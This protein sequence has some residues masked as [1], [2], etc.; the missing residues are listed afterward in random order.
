MQTLFNIWAIGFLFMM[1]FIAVRDKYCDIQAGV[2]VGI[3]WPIAIALI[4]YFG[5]L[6]YIK[7]KTG[8]RT[9]CE[10]SRKMFNYRRA[11]NPHVANGYAITIFWIEL[12][13]W[14]P[15]S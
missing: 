15:N 2:F 6:H 13:F 11:N 5:M 7:I 10:L 4:P 3:I 8:W 1:V 9:D 12:Q 14:K